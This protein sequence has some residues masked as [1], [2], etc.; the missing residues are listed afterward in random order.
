M[1]GLNCVDQGALDGLLDP[2]TGV[3]AESGT[4]RGVKPFNGLD[5]ADVA[6]FNQ[7]GEW[8][9]AVGVVLGD[10]DH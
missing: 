9:A 1:N 4:L 10:G 8:Q 5:E 2:P 7:V 3:G 6:L